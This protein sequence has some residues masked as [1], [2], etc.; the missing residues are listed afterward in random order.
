[1]PVVAGAGTCR[2]IR[3]GRHM[4]RCALTPSIVTTGGAAFSGP[5]LAPL[6]SIS[7]RGSAAAGEKWSMRGPEP[8]SAS[9]WGRKRGM[10]KGA[11]ALKPKAQQRGYSPSIQPCG[12]VIEDDAPAF[13]QRLQLPRRPRLGDVEE[14]KKHQRDKSVLPIGGAA[15]QRYPLAGNLVNDHKPRIFPSALAR[16]NRCCRYADRARKHDARNQGQQKRLRGRMRSHG[17]C[18]PQ[19]QRR[20]RSPRSRRR[21]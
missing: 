11:M 21:L 13:R 7:P 9:V 10:W 17:K 8:L 16:R 12:K 4:R 18:G 15:E 2:T 5:R 3:E 20:Q 14:P 1:M 19:Q 6:T